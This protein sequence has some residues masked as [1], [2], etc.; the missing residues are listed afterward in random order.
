MREFSFILDILRRDCLVK[1]LR[2][3]T[4]GFCWDLFLERVFSEGLAGLVFFEIKKRNLK[5]IFPSKEVV[6]R[7]ASSIETATIA[8]RSL[9]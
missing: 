4:R 5:E 9:D 2:E 3:R 6:L 8:I 1:E 7:W